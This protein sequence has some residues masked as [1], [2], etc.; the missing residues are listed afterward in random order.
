MVKMWKDIHGG[1][2]G[3]VVMGGDSH[4]K[5]RARIPAP[6]TAWT[7]LPL[8]CKNCKV[9]LKRPIKTKRGRKWPTV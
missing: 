5:G 4:C 2:P 1:S 3:L 7:F 9:C 6:D 8:Y